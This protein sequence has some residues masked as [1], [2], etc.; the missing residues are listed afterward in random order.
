MKV[1]I[2]YGP[3]Y[4][5]AIVHLDQGEVIRAESGAMVSMDTHLKFETSA[6]QGKG[7]KGF[8]KALGRSLF[9]GESFFQN[10]FTAESGPGTVTL[11]PQMVGDIVQ[12]QLTGNAVMIT[13]SCYVAGHPSIEIKTKWG[14]AKSFFG[15]EGLFMMR[16]EG[17]GPLVMSAFGAV[18]EMDIDGDFI[19]DT[20]HIVAFEES[21]T[22]KVKRVGSWFST[23]F[24]GEG[25]VTQF[26]G[27]GKLWI[28][29]R[30]PSAF[31]KLIGPKLPPRQQ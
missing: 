12:H 8:F 28:Q 31:G 25:L 1:N 13:S 18:H 19:V 6:S 17:T 23:F 30:N 27:K 2:E 14:G 20:G 4:A 10:T 21:L 11:A 16:A 7:I 5:L 22:F 24:S 15:G 9:S 3:S 26:S 29:S